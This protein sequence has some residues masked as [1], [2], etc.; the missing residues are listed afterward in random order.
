MI[1]YFDLKPEAQA[2]AI[3]NSGVMEWAI[4]RWVVFTSGD[5]NTPRSPSPEEIA[6]A[7]DAADV[8]AVRTYTKLVALKN[9]TPAQVSAWVDA[10]VTNLAQIQDA[11]KTLAMLDGIL[12]RRL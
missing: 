12:A 9:M 10:N 11:L 5:I 7:A 1:K 8:A 3:A 4:S 2:F 6:V